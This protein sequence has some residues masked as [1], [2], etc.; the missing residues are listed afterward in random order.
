MPVNV[1]LL[2]SNGSGKPLDMV[3]NI[4]T[5][6]GIL[7]I[8]Q[9]SHHQIHDENSYVIS[10]V[11]NV[12]TTTQKWMIT[13]PK[14]TKHVHILVPIECTGEMLFQLYEG[15]THTI[16]TRLIPYNRD[17]NSIKKSDVIVRRTPAGGADGTVIY[18]TRVG[19]TGLASKTI[20]SGGAR[21]V[22]EFILASDTKYVVSITTYADVYV[23]FISNWYMI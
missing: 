21:G 17:R 13:T 6:S 14:S 5:L 7:T 9:D 11:V 19:S 18:S 4:D 2:T 20:S 12:N 8:I 15:S 10:D 1:Q 3:L 22:N 16:G 23:S